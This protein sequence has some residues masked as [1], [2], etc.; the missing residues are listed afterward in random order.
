[1]N[2]TNSLFPEDTP[3]VRASIRAQLTRAAFGRGH[4][5]PGLGA[6]AGADLFAPL[7][8]QPLDHLGIS[9]TLVGAVRAL[10]LRGDMQIAAEE[11][12]R[13][14]VRFRAQPPISAF[15]GV[16]SRDEKGR[17]V[18]L[19]Y[20]LLGTVPKQVVRARRRLA[21]QRDRTDSVVVVM[22]GLPS[23]P[24]VDGVVTVAEA[25]ELA[26]TRATPCQGHGTAGSGEIAL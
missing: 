8:C 14:R 22:D 1:M 26:G 5:K 20:P 21:R 10:S 17:R 19:Q 11:L 15:Y 13:V 2:E 24:A 23:L 4:T 7:A 3:T 25:C 18:Y 6:A 16:P 12:R 9:A